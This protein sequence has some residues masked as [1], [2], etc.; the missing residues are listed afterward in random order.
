MKEDA[1]SVLWINE[2]IYEALREDGWKEPRGRS[3]YRARERADRLL[4][5][6]KVLVR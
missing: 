2:L 5:T 6:S 4:D 1:N 3:Q